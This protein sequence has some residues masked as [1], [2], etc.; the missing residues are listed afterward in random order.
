MKH[1][2]DERHVGQTGRASLHDMRMHAR[3]W[4][5]QYRDEVA[6]ARRYCGLFHAADAYFWAAAWDSLDRAVTTTG[7]YALEMWR[8]YRAAMYQAGM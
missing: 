7:P 5:R 3:S 2:T 8:Q 1:T 6:F 4:T